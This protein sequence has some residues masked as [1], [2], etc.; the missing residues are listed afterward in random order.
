MHVLEGG[1]KRTSGKGVNSR[2]VA[3][4]EKEEHFKIK[5]REEEKEMKAS[6]PKHMP[7]CVALAGQ[8]GLRRNVQVFEER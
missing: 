8:V 5:P 3:S 6:L 1:L 2:A 7:V 4:G